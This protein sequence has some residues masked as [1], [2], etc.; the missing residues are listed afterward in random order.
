V[1]QILQA[2]I[3]RLQDKV[4]DLEHQLSLSVVSTGNYFKY[5]GEVYTDILETTDSEVVITSKKYIR[6]LLN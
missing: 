6:R 5:N 4:A 3:K 1:E 2:E